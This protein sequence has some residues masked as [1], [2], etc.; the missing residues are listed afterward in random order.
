MKKLCAS[1]CARS[2]HLKQCSGVG[3]KD[4]LGL[5]KREISSIAGG[6]RQEGLGSCMGRELR[7]VVDSLSTGEKMRGFV[8]E[9]W[10]HCEPA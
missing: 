2:L 8:Y 1:I 9:K 3:W 7:P 4:F 5:R 6:C 10:T